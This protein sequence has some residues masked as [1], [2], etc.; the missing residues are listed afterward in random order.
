MLVQSHIK[1]RKSQGKPRV[2]QATSNLAKQSARRVAMA[3]HVGGKRGAGVRFSS[4][5]RPA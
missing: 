2:L 1:A 3:K 4:G 5:C